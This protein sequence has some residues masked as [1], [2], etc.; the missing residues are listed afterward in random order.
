MIFLYFKFTNYLKTKN[1]LE[2]KNN[3][4]STTPAFEYSGHPS[5]KKKPAGQAGREIL[6]YIKV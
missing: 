3:T 6:R 5:L 2:I 1:E 4:F